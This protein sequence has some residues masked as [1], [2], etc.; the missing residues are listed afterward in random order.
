MQPRL[1]LKFQSSCLDLLRSWTY[2]PVPAGSLLFSFEFN[3][4]S[5]KESS[6]SFPVLRQ[7]PEDY[8][9]RKSYWNPSFALDINEPLLNAEFME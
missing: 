6:R 1:A 2:K 8:G 5:R 7:E 9:R 3:T 4:F